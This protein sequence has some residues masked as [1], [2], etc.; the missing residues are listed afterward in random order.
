MKLLHQRQEKEFT[1][2]DVH[3]NHFPTNTVLFF[4][5]ELVFINKAFI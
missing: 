3:P 5:K 2:K 4:M 1:Q